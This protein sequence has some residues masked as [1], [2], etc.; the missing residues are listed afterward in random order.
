M[1][2]YSQIIGEALA[3]ALLCV[4]AGVFAKDRVQW[5]WA[6]AAIGLLLGQKFLLYLTMD[7]GP[8]IV[9]GR[10]NWEGKLAAVAFLLAVGFLVFRD[11]RKEWGWTLRQDGPAPRAGLIAAGCI[12]VATALFVGLYFPGTKSEPMADWMYQL[13]MPSLHEELFYR[14]LLLFLLMKA[15]PP[16]AKI[17][18]APMGWAAVIVTAQF[19]LAHVLLVTPGWQVSVNWADFLSLILGGLWVYVRVATGSLLFPV[20][21]HSLSNT[22]G[23]L[24]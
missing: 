8:E 11:D 24:F 2:I 13:T 21:L 17:L 20:L 22:V 3:L 18:G 23:Y 15:F 4:G 12:A 14:G 6:L 9:G 7:L 10:Y 16:G 5:K 19:Y 1:G